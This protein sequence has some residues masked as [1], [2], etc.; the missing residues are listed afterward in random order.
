MIATISKDETPTTPIPA[1]TVMLMRE[2]SGDV[3]VLM[4]ERNKAMGAF[5]GVLAFPGGKLMDS[6]AS[7]G[8]RAL[9]DGGD[10]LDDFAFSL[11]IAARPL[12]PSEAVTTVCPSLST[13]S[14]V[15]ST[16]SGSS[17]TMST[18]FGISCPSSTRFASAAGGLGRLPVS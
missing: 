9:A 6:D 2:G 13:T 8:M 11:R 1:A 14:L 17:S 4:T 10:D 5:G 16:A 3:E 7:A 18:F 15:K 12:D